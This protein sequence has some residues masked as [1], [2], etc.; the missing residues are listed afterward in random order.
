MIEQWFVKLII[1]Y[2]KQL[3]LGKI[4]NVRECDSK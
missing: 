4:V 2:T 1:D 3:W